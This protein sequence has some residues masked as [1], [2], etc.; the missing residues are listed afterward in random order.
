MSGEMSRLLGR[1]GEE[2]AAAYL[3]ER[4]Y[5][6]LACNWR[7]RFG[8]LDLV[9]EDGAFLC[10]VEVKLRRS[11]RFGAGAEFVDERKQA[12]L[13]MTAAL[14]L[15]ACPTQLQPRF[16]VACVDILPDGELVLADYL[17]NAFGAE[18]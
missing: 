11:E 13:R 17:E 10:F 4:G 18:E 12:R 2:Q 7:C 14:Y 16:D 9:A 15:Q 3:R 1:W 6:I 5:A 8:E